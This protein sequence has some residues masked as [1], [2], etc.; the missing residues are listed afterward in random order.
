MVQQRYQMNFCKSAEIPTAWMAKL[1]GVDC[2]C[3]PL[4]IVLDLAYRLG[5]LNFQSLM[6]KI[7]ARF[8]RRGVPWTLAELKR[9]GQKPDS[10]LARRLRRTI[11]EVV[12]TGQSRRVGLPIPFRRWTS[13]EIKR[14][15]TLTDAELSRRLRRP[16]HHIRNQ[17]LA[18][19][20][21]S[22]KPRGPDRQWSLAKIRLIGTR[23]DKELAKQAN[24][25]CAAVAE[26][27]WALKI[28]AFRPPSGYSMR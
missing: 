18:F 27:R 14:L 4:K 1:K 10:V 21:P 11:Q 15:G 17:R 7:S 3:S 2:G 5:K 23:P 12:F 24:R 6:G 26:R 8:R 9:L 13:G 28:P 20:I 22:F 16:E 19:K 25:S